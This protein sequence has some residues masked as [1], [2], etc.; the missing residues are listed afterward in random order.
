MSEK[1][2]IPTLNGQDCHEFIVRAELHKRKESE[3]KKFYTFK[4]NMDSPNG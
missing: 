3:Y 1:K 2:D 4:H